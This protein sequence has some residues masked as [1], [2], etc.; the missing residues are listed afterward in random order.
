MNSGTS[1]SRRALLRLL[2]AS[3]SAAQLAQS[4][5]YPAY[6]ESNRLGIPGLFPGRVIGIEHQGSLADGT[7]YSPVIEQMFR[8]GMKELTGAP[9]WQD[10][11]RLFFE[12]GDVVGIKVNPA[13]LPYIV[14]SPEVLWQIV[15]GLNAA[16]IK[17]SDMIVYDRYREEFYGAGMDRWIPEGVR[18]MF[19][20]VRWDERQQLIDGY[21]PDHFMEM[22]IA[23]PG[24]NVDDPAARRSYAAQF[25]TRAVNKLVNLTVLKDHQAAGITLALK[26]LSNGLVNNVNR[27]HPDFTRNYS[28]AFIPA[29]VSL[30]VIRNKAVLH[31]IDGV[32]GLYHS[33]PHSQP[34]FLWQHDTL[35]FSTDP[36]ALDRVGW[37]V[38]DQKRISVGMQPVQ[39]APADE[40]SHWSN[41]Q[42]EHVEI[43]GMMGLGEWD[44]AR[45]YY[46]HIKLDAQPTSPLR[47]QERL[48]LPLPSGKV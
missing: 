22:A 17:R 16:G 13:G 14:S 24:Q 1:L 21:D 41:R 30:P 45:I 12:P 11:W 48:R 32:K 42:P 34:Q 36:V 7:Y 10:G 25:I 8:R 47:E 33:G 44:L 20:T 46:R 43:A 23:L 28:G 27:S 15:R 40:F 35:Y 4:A 38:I 19:A 6:P 9:D 39:L 3:V 26:N 29:V 18:T 2:G 31:I 5:T 37:T